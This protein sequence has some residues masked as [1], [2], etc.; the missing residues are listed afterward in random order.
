MSAARPSAYNNPNLQMPFIPPGRGSIGGVISG[1]AGEM[2]PSFV[3]DGKRMRKAITRRTIDL[4]SS[5]IR[6]FEDQA[7]PDKPLSHSPYASLLPDQAFVINVGRINTFF[8][9][10]CGL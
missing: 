2:G 5:M 4:S 8:N 10:F 6:M 7:Q 9:D 3:Y 1:G